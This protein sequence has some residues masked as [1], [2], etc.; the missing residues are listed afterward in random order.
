[1]NKKVVLVGPLPPP[2]HGMSLSNAVI[3]S[4]FTEHDSYEFLGINTF[5]S[6]EIESANKQGVFDFTKLFRSLKKYFLD[7]KSLSRFRADIYYVT[8]PQSLLGF[9]RYIPYLL[10]AKYLGGK[11][12]LHFHGSKF[13]QLF[14][15]FMFLA[16]QPIMNRLVTTVIVLGDSLRVGIDDYF[17][18]EKVKVVP[19][20]VSN[21]FTANN[22]T[23]IKGRDKFKVLYLSNLMK[24]KGIVDFLLAIKNAPHLLE[25]YE[26]VVAGE[27]D[28]SPEDVKALLN[29]L[30]HCVEY[31]GVVTGQHK[32]ALFNDCD[33]FVLPSYNEGQPISILEAYISQCMVITTNVGGI[34]DIFKDGVNGKFI[35]VGNPA[36]LSL[37]LTDLQ[38]A[39]VIMMG[40]YNKQ[41]ALEKFTEEAF[42]KR[43]ESAI[44]SNI[45]V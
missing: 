14:S 40:M 22:L 5:L 45:E 13:N 10:I 25:K 20:G 36:S 18:H 41:L 28:S 39:E 4:F 12:C 3:S 42:L 1:M 23:L 8:P 15:K 32:V 17:G 19:N 44:M 21:I 7:L 33:I 9:C 2:V 30:S 29:E 11:V 31:R 34:P 38:A 26:F 24:T 27:F 16:L 6:T 35:E 37:L 43:V